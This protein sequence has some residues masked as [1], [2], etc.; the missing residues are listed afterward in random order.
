MF[1]KHKPIRLKGKALA[2]LNKRIHDR[3]GD[4]CLLCGDPVDP[5][6]KFHHIDFKSH[7]GDD[8][9]ENGATVCIDCHNFAHGPMAPGVRA[10]LK[11]RIHG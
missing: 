3:D 6:E 7:G 11:R 1:P 5:G 9:E 10:E 4:C 2:E 8:S